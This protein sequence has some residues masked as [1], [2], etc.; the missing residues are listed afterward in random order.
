M[1]GAGL[2]GPW[3]EYSYAIY[4]FSKDVTKLS[5]H[6]TLKVMLI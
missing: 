2:Q 4:F 3:Q 6:L 5:S 1:T